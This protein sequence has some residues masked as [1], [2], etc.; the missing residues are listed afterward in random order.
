MFV[1][2]RKS[3]R[4]KVIAGL[5]GYDGKLLSSSLSTEAEEHLRQGVRAARAA[6][7]AAR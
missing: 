2:V 3:T 1:L 7:A 5:A 6:T 4:D